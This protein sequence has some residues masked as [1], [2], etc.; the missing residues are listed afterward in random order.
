MQMIALIDWRGAHDDA[1]YDPA[2]MQF[3]TRLGGTCKGCI[4]EKQRVSVC[5]KAADAAAL[6]GLADCDTGVIYIL[7]AQDPRQLNLVEGV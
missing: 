6:A 5:R 3:T 1:S 4:F 2:S 7:R